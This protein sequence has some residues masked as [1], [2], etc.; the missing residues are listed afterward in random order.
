MNILVLFYSMTGHTAELAYAIQ[1]GAKSAGAD[2][3]LRQVPELLTPEVINKYPNIKKTRESLAGIPS[4]TYEDLLWADGIAF[5]SPT[6][7]GNMTAQMKEFL[8]GTG[9]LW[10]NNLLVGKVACV[11]TSTATQHGGQETTLTSMMLPLLHLGFTII[12]LPYSEQ[13]QSEM[14]QIHGGSPYGVSSVSGPDGQL[15]ATDTDLEL[16]RALGKRLALVAQ[17]L[18]GIDWQHAAA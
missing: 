7:Y 12:G 13:K 17:R 5:G 4:A 8:D 1:E 14:T 16:A 10:M 15:K 2:V 18:T 11:F 6:R 3:K 9:A